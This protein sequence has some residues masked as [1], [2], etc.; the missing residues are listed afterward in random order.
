MTNHSTDVNQKKRRLILHIGTH[1]TGTTT[2]QHLCWRN[3]EELLDNGWLYPF[4][5]R[6]KYD[7]RPGHH[8]L[9]FSVLQKPMEQRPYWAQKITSINVTEEWDKLMEELSTFPD[10]NVILSS[11]AI[12][13]C[14]MESIETIKNIISNFD[15]S[16]VI[17]LRNQRDYLISSYKQRVKKSGYTQSFREFVKGRIILNSNLKMVGRWATIFGDECI[18]IRL[19]DKVVESSGLMQDFF[20]IMGLP[21]SII[22]GM[23]LNERINSSPND[24]TTYLIRKINSYIKNINKFLVPRFKLRIIKFRPNEKLSQNL[25]K[26]ANIGL[27]NK[28][29]AY[30]SD[31]DLLRNELLLVD[32]KLLTKYISVEDLEYLKF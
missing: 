14:N 8:L 1:K 22:L 16:I 10:K 26:I 18:N 19:Y 9:S 13:G 31:I 29:V 30:E 12:G 4:N 32:D 5:G 23:S 28:K 17:Y 25:N 7:F 2:I 15:V 21:D 27:L 3:R 24:N 20:N 11:E 6:P